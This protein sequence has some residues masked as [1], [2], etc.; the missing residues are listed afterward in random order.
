MHTNEFKRNLEKYVE[1]GVKVGVN[2]QKGQRLVI[3]APVSALDIVRMAAKSAY[4][5]GAKDVYLDWHDDVITR[6]KYDMAPD[7]AF[8][9][10]PLW[11][12]KGYEEMA[13][14]GA[15]FLYY[16]SA[17]PELLKG[18]NPDRLAAARRVQGAA[19]KNFKNA[20]MADQVSWSI[21]SIPSPS[22]A[23]KVFPDLPEEE[24]MAKLWDNV[25]KAT[26]ADQDDPVA[27]WN[28]HLDILRTKAALLNEKKYKALHYQAPG[29]D[30]TVELAPGHLWIAGE[31][32][33]A[34]GDMFVANIPTEEV[35]T[36]PLREGVNGTVRNTKPL[37]F[38]GNV[39]DGFTL[40]FKDGR[41]VDFSA[42][43]G[44]DTLK[45]L[46][47]TDDGSH[48]LGEVALVPHRSPISETNLIFFDT[49]YDENASNH[50]AIGTAYAFSVEGGKQMT[51]EQLA[52]QGLNDSLVHVD[53][54]IGS[55]QMNIDGI[56]ADGKREPIFRNGN[57][58]E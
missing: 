41:I 48:Y 26:R 12:A 3:S 50:M 18:V 13:A 30:L 31:S 19:M 40:T 49:L 51:K 17:N 36:A 34:Q 8:D 11:R 1:L 10:F 22:W 45:S 56:T 5:A 27:A 46:I 25:F 55:E 23:A 47:D 58:A 9:E 6:L 39:I 32:F 44:Y 35:F 28:D 24:A 33:N 21:Q 2:V 43:T 14:E 37:N 29:T 53:F 42:E 16:R 54:M 20:Q 52:A 15:A 4:E 38:G 7:E 57:W